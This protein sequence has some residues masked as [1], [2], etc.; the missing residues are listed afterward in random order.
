[1]TDS[2]KRYR[3]VADVVPTD[4]KGLQANFCREL[5]RRTKREEY[6]TPAMRM[7][8]AKGPVRLQTILSTD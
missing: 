4:H 5:D 3:K 1:M 6:L 8:L 7:Y 2:A